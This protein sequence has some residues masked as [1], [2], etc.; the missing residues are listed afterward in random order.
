MLSKKE[1]LTKAAFDRSFA[2]GKRFHTPHFQIIYTKAATFHGAVV[3][4][5]KVYKKA[6][7][8]N[9]LRRQLYGAL[10]RTHQNTPLPYTCIIVAK[11]T[12]TTVPQKTRPARLT[13]ALATLQKER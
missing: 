2:M 6:V 11:P 8:R 4:G 12:L 9:R 1:R 10:Y 7:D 13:E 3:V 5:K